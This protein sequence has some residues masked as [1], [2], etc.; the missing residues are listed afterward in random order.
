MTSGLFSFLRQLSRSKD[1]RGAAK[2]ALPHPPRLLF[3]GFLLLIFLGTALLKLPVATTAPIG[4]LDAAFTATSA[5]T[6]TGLT[7]VDTGTQFTLF[8]Q[9]VILGLIQ[10]GGLGLMTFAVLT[11]VTLGFRLQL[12]HQLLA[13]EAFN[14]L[15]LQ[16]ARRAA[17][18]IALFA[19]G[20]E[21][22]G[23][24]T[25][26]LFLVPQL[27]WAEG[28]YQALFYTVSA[29]NNAGFSLS[30]DSLG[31]WAGQ[32]GIL[33]T[34]SALF[35][36]GGLGY[37]VVMEVLQKRRWRAF[38]VYTRIILIATILINLLAFVLVFLL[39]MNNPETLGSLSTG[40]QLLAAWFQATTPRTAGF[41][42]LDIGSLTMATSLL[43]MAL[44]FIG[45]APNSTASGI[46]LSTL[47]VLIAT[48][49]SFLKGNETVFILK[50]SITN[51]MVMKALATTA[52]GVLVI[53][54][55]TFA[56][57]LF[58]KDDFLNLLFE[59]ISAFGT[60]GLSRGTTEH[61]GPGGQ[62]IIMLV[63]LIGRLGPLMLGYMLMVRKPSSV[64]YAR[65][66]FPV[67]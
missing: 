35:I 20:T 11:A 62:G 33:L 59:V 40:D 13:Q 38:S 32:P 36:L 61:L 19:L 2:T 52:I 16:D 17:L 8:G 5:V 53:F 64:K 49:R 44:M 55:A 14:E 3:E 54:A 28:A 18:S 30:S 29:F 39:E 45:G 25:L 21:A 31:G 24:A 50:R 43:L 57:S 6:V 67:G 46:K 37:I 34:V 51:D 15:S 9:L 1:P 27:G 22:L 7:V 12:R 48:T 60:V 56:L 23:V 58:V 42:T 26:S 41:N 10:L 4:W 66:E 65:V 63:M 47:A